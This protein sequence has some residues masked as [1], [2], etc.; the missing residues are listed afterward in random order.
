MS[1]S[2]SPL[3]YDSQDQKI[4]A[5]EDLYS[6]E[7]FTEEERERYEG[8]VQTTLLDTPII[9]EVK[10]L[11]PKPEMQFRQLKHSLKDIL[12]SVSIK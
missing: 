8:W 4:S 12:Y 2:I 10:K 1:I 3:D 7:I 9:P 6:T 11:Y 5:I